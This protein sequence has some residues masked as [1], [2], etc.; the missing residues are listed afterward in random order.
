MGVRAPRTYVTRINATCCPQP[1]R[2]ASLRPHPTTVSDPLPRRRVNALAQP[3]ARC[4]AALSSK[5]HTACYY[6]QAKKRPRRVAAIWSAKT[7]LAQSPG[8]ALK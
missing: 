4:K 3:S 7:S 6:K 5:R 8:V 2:S 1:P